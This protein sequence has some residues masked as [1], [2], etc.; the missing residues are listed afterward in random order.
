MENEIINENSS[1]K[2]A[3]NDAK[4][5]D[6][7][8]EL[9]QLENLD[10]LEL[11]CEQ[12]D[13]LKNQLSESLS[14][15]EIN[16]STCILAQNIEELELAPNEEIKDYILRVK[17]YLSKTTVKCIKAEYM[18]IEFEVLHDSNLDDVFNEY[19]A[20]YDETYGISKMLS[21]LGLK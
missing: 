18:G 6:K 1:N 13:F 10:E 17:N 2:F 20:K 3:F 5:L 12:L 8:Q 19:Y 15:E 21:D 14:E 7:I 9:L 11:T 4:I 16:D